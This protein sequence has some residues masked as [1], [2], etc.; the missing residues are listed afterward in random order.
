M[1]CQVFQQYVRLMILR[2]F[3]CLI[4]L[5]QKTLIPLIGNE[6]A[7]SFK[8]IVYLAHVHHVHIELVCFID[9]YCTLNLLI[10]KFVLDLSYKQCLKFLPNLI[11][12]KFAK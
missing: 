9:F 11:V 6:F 2:C 3:P 10:P 4:N 12:G 8:I 5:G 7:F 1:Q